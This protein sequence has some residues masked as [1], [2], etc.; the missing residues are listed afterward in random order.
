MA[1]TRETRVLDCDCL[2]RECRG[3]LY[4]LL[5]ERTRRDNASGNAPRCSAQEKGRTSGQGQGPKKL[6]A[7]I[8]S[9]FYA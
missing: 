6:I 3:Q 4:L 8:S 7:S 1:A 9:P 2:V 5:G